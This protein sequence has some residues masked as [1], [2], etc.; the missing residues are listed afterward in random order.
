MFVRTCYITKG[1]LAHMYANGNVKYYYL[2]LHNFEKLKGCIKISRHSYFTKF[3][4]PDVL[5]YLFAK[6]LYLT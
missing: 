3:R 1:P 5:D 6:H 2:K 4:F